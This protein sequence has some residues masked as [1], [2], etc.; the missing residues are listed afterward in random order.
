M[1]VSK[2]GGEE[3]E[4]APPIRREQRGRGGSVKE[5]EVQGGFLQIAIVRFLSNG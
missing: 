1:A 5:R 2:R 3:T 4:E